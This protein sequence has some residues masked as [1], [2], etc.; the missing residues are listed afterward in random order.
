VREDLKRKFSLLVCIEAKRGNRKQ[1]KAKKYALFVHF[2]VK[3]KTERKKKR[4]NIHEILDVKYM[5]NGS[6]FVSL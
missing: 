1:N 2:H 5:P 3:L 6:R 4:N